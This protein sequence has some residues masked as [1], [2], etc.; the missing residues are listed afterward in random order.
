MHEQTKS[1][2]KPHKRTGRVAALAVP[3]CEEKARP[4]ALERNAGALR[5]SIGFSGFLIIIIVFLPPN[6]I[7]IIKAPTLKSKEPGFDRLGVGWGAFKFLKDARKQRP[8]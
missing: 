1:H 5:I 2:R 8:S 4:V 7:L 6:P 3:A